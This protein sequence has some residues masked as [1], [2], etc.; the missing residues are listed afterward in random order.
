MEIERQKLIH[1]ADAQE[2]HGLTKEFMN[3]TNQSQ[4]SQK[5]TSCLITLP[6]PSDE[7]N[8]Q[9][10]IYQKNENKIYQAIHSKR[11]PSRSGLHVIGVGQMRTGTTSL[12]HALEL[13]LNG[14]CYHMSDVVF[15]YGEQHMRLWIEACRLSPGFAHEPDYQQ[16]IPSTLWDSIYG[17]AKS[18]VDYPSCVFYRQLMLNYPDAKFILTV[19]DPDEWVRSCR[20]TTMRP[21][22]L[23]PPSISERIYCRL[24]GIASLPQ[25]HH[26]MFQ[27]AFGPNY[28]DMSDD[29]L[30]RSY[31]HWN[32]TI[33]QNIPADRLLMFEPHQGWA[34]LCEFLHVPKPPD[35]VPFPHLNKRED[36]R[37]RLEGFYRN[38]RR[39]SYLLVTL[40]IFGLCMLFYISFSL[41][42]L[43]LGWT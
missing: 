42:M 11:T 29:E 35:S 23:N 1:T 39:I 12:K 28:S 34:P 7:K 36:M 41:R 5:L 40:M 6:T 16:T 2:E 14:H 27:R 31:T 10:V 25:L 17:S 32:E 26:H 20:A 15:E 21:E 9:T 13:L 19:R 4:P 18:A 8:F 43:S 33:K 38:V 37:L 22:I 3:P 24:R 30:K